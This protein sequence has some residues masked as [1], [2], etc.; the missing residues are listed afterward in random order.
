[1]R[2]IH[3]L[4]ALWRLSGL[5]GDGTCRNQTRAGEK[6]PMTARRQIEVTADQSLEWY[7]D[8]HIY[9]AR[10]HARAV[11]GDMV[12]EADLLS[13]HERENPPGAPKGTQS[14]KQLTNRRRTA[15]VVIST[16]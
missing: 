6:P 5:P 10:G 7:Q 11:R 3:Y 13:A 9:V 15:A 8:A 12:V 4:Y 2:L 16:S 14:R 1:M